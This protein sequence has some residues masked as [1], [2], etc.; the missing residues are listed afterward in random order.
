MFFGLHGVKCHG[1]LSACRLSVLAITL[2]SIVGGFLSRRRM[3]QFA[4]R[5]L[6]HS[7]VG[8]KKQT[9]EKRIVV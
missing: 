5:S 7:K 6:D 9:Q 1:M 8:L 4:E 2:D 3:L